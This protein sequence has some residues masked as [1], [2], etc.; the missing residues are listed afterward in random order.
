MARRSR[1][2]SLRRTGFLLVIALFLLLLG[3]ADLTLIVGAAVLVLVWA[4]VLAPAYCGAET[5]RTGEFCRNNSFGLLLGCHLRQHRS[6]KFKM[7]FL[8]RRFAHFTRGMF[9]T[10]G[11]VVATV[12]GVFG[13]VAPVIG[14]VGQ[15]LGGPAS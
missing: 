10:P 1:K 2:G 12:S 14:V 11:A 5:R 3:R 15:V 7:L 9:S 6:Q 13:I 8:Q 4:L